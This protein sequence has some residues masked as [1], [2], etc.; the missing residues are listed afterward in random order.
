MASSYQNNSGTNN[1]LRTSGNF[2]VPNQGLSILFFLILTLFLSSC[3]PQSDRYA[4]TPTHQS[5]YLPGGATPP[6]KSTPIAE[7]LQLPLSVWVDPNLPFSVRDL[8][9]NSTDLEYLTQTENHQ[10]KIVPTYENIIGYWVYLVVVPF[11]SSLNIIQADDLLSLWRFGKSEDLHLFLNPD[12]MRSLSSLWGDPNQNDLTITKSENLIAELW[13]NPNSIAIV[14]FHELEAQMKVL[15]IDGTNPLDHN[16][17]PAAYSLSLPI[18]LINPLELNVSNYFDDFSNYFRDKLT[19]IALTGVTAMVRDTASIMEENGVTYPASDI[20]SILTNVDLTH[21]SN[22]VPFAEDC[23]PPDS[24]QPS[25]FFCSKDEYIEL[26]E[27][28]GTDIVELSGDHFGDYGPEAILHSLDLYHQRNWLTYGGGKT[29]QAGL[30]PIYIEHNGNHIAFIGCNGK[31]HD[32]YA[33]A[34][35]DNPGASRCDFEWMMPT[36][37]HLKNEGYLVIATMQHEEVDSFGSIA[38]QRYD[39]RRIADAGATIIS[40]SQA[41]HPQAVEF[42]GSSFIHYGLGNLFFDQWYLATRNPTEHKNKD[43]AFIDIHY[44]YDGSYINT[45]LIPLQFID[46]ARS[47]PM[48]FEESVEFLSELHRASVWNIPAE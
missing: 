16:F 33:S 47:R 6:V 2:I 31:I 7:T 24:N 30:D 25:L 20:Q 13:D 15:S 39:F 21:I 9:K 17:S 10:F 37:T 22:E 26:L 44:F 5:I 3:S 34:T 14:P 8:V 35:E 36:I 43:K 4:L 12:T 32:L 11:N 23:P 48:T 29:L 27:A 1:N 19:S 40:G 38:I 46:N 28:I 41:H 18:S 45:R 42:H